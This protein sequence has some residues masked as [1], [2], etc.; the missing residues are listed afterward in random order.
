LGYT[1]YCTI[2]QSYTLTSSAA[3]SAQNDFQGLMILG[4]DIYRYIPPSLR[5]CPQNMNN[6]IHLTQGS[7][8]TNKVIVDYTSPALCIPVSPFPPTGDAAY[9]QRPGRGPSHGHRLHAQIIGKDR[10]GGSGGIL[11][12]KRTHRQTYSSQYFASA[13]AGEVTNKTKQ[14]SMWANAQRDG[15]RAEYRWR[16]L[17][18]AAKFG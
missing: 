5:H 7:T 3:I 4:G 18:N 17:F 14:T 9:C 8:K 6:F 2:L 11:S 15:R 10:A 12:D 16:P 1:F 13:S